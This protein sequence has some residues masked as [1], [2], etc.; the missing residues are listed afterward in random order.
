[1][2]PDES[3]VYDFCTELSMK[4]EVSDATFQRARAIF[5][6]QQVVDLIVTS[7]TYVTVAMLTN[8]SEEGLPP[9]T[10]L[11]PQSLPTH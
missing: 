8:A 2:R 11:P 1:M 7:G 5:S 3:I 10:A 4:H 9:G 6:E